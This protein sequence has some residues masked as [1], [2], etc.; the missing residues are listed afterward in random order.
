MKYY[1][2]TSS[3]NFNN[4]LST[5]SI[6]PASFYTSRNF[7]YSRWTLVPENPHQNMVLLYDSPGF[8]SRPVCDVEDHP[9]LIEIHTNKDYPRLKDGVYYSERT[10]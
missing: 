3:L 5:E 7:G 6:S 8:F 9:L 10:V 4:I 2:P 1:I